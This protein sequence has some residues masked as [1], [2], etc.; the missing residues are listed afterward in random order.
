MVLTLYINAYN[1]IFRKKLT[2]CLVV[3]MNHGQSDIAP[4]PAHPPPLPQIFFFFPP[5]TILVIGYSP[6]K[7]LEPP[8]PPPPP[9]IS[10]ISS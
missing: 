3:A 7:K 9:I 10:K 1:F 8:P 2:M 4:W 6:P 5:T